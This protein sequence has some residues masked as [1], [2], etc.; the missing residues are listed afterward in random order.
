MIDELRDLAL[1]RP[2]SL[3][4]IEF[5]E[6]MKKSDIFKW[7]GVTVEQ[8]RDIINECPSLK[9]S[10]VPERLLCKYRARDSD[11][12]IASSFHISQRRREILSCKRKIM[13]SVFLRTQLPRTREYLT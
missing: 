7:T 12:R 3:F 10:K 9:H 11:Y 1:S 13:P 6:G 4:N 2:S 8:F 5:F